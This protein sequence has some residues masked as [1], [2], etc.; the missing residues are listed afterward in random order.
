MRKCAFP[1]AAVAVA[2]GIGSGCG[3]RTPGVTN[4]NGGDSDAGG[5][6]APTP[7]ALSIETFAIPLE[8]VAGDEVTAACVVSQD[9]DYL[10]G[11]ETVVAVSPEAGAL[12][13]GT[14]SVTFTPT[15]VGSYVVHCETA[16]GLTVDEKGVTIE[17]LAG[18]PASV[19]TMISDNVA[20]AGASVSADCEVFDAFGNLID[21]EDYEQTTGLF[22]PDELWPDPLSGPG[23]TVRGTTAGDYEVACTY[24]ELIDETPEPLT[25]VPG[26]PAFTD[27]IVLPTYLAPTEEATIECVV[28]DAFGNDLVGVETNVVAMVADGSLAMDAGLTY[29]DA[30]ISATLAQTYYVSCKVPAFFAGDETP[31]EVVVHPGLP[32]HWIVELPDQDCFWQDRG[33]PLLYIVYDQWGNE[34]ASEDY[35]ITVWSDPAGVTLDG[36]GVVRIPGEGD[37]T[38]WVDLAGTTPQAANSTI[39][40]IGS[41]VRV[42][43][44]PPVIDI[45]SPSRASALQQSTASVSISG[46]VS[47]G[48]SAIESLEINDNVIAVTPGVTSVPISRT[49]NS[50]WGLN[51]ITG[52]AVDEC[53]NRRVIAQSY[54]RS[55]QYFT[56]A[57]WSSSTARATSG[58]LARLNQPVIDDGNRNDADDLATITWMI[59]TGMDLDAVI[60]STFVNTR[61]W[62]CTECGFWPVEWDDCAW[63]GYRVL[64]TSAFT[65]SQPTMDW[66]YAVDGGLSLGMSISNLYLPLNVHG[67]WNCH[68]CGD[69]DVSVNGDISVN[70]VWIDAELSVALSGTNPSVS[71]CSSCLT[72]GFNNLD[73]DIDWGL[74]D[75]LGDAT[76]GWIINLIIDTFQDEIE[77]LLASEL[78]SAIPPMVEDFLSGFELEA[79]FDIP[80]P[81]SMHLNLASGMDFIDFDGPTGSGNGELGLYTQVYPSARAAAIP[82]SSR[83]TIRRRPAASDGPGPGTSFSSSQYNFGLGL[84]DDVLNQ[85]MWALWYGGGLELN[86]TE[87][88]ALSGSFD[89]AGVD[90]SISGKLPPVIM[91]GS[92]TNQIYIG[93]G[94]MYIDASVDLAI[95]LG[96]DD[97]T[98]PPL[99]VGMYLS[100]VLGG[101]LDLDPTNNELLV[102]LD[103]NPDIWIEVVAIDDEGYQGV[104]TDLFVGLMTVLL[105]PMLEQVV[106]SFPIP[107]FDLGGLAGLPAGT[108]LELTNGSLGRPN[109]ANWCLG[110]TEK[111]DATHFC[112]TG[113]L[114]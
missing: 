81:L 27:T 92:G 72:I 5:T 94:D 58:I 66:L 106:G 57:T 46:T 26:I 55:G 52:S 109:T 87:I 23:F 97:S 21:E 53:G 102:A 84:E 83:G 45:S 35:D 56:A 9:R 70:Y 50:E 89:L 34:V 29:D 64:K 41:S 114:Q 105:P 15:E 49:Q 3:S 82:S 93:L 86:L 11:I 73:L 88:L 61:V 48:V 77:D 13:T 69:Y 12:T 8:L 71:I 42:D 47:D 101:F 59:L 40:P 10:A 37:F 22:L 103:P 44:T 6:E 32:H 80:A 20:E 4:N 7:V 79:G 17:V 43:S 60:P 99:H 39:V 95:L 19:E 67:W 63:D 1:L 96:I 90:L 51:V 36:D 18:P 112:L 104:M 65:Y 113:S 62:D 28:Q 31:A 2:I 30:S 25:I 54:L 107:S 91:P 76:L 74:L 24:G 14:T 33:L 100:T 38:I 75:F 85:V 78:R 110:G 16:D 108:V 68:C 111:M 98:A